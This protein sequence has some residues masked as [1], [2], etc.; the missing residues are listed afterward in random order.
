[1]PYLTELHAHSRE[2]SPCGQK[3]VQEVVDLY[4]AAGYHSLVLTN[5]YCD[6]VMNMPGKDW[7]ERYAHY[8]SAY[9]AMREYAGDRMHILLGAELRFEGMNNDYLIFGLTEEL[10]HKFPDLHKMTLKSFYPLAKDHGLLVIQAHPFRHGMQV[11]R[12]DYL[13][14][15]EIFNGHPGHDSRND[16]ARIWCKKYGKLPTSGSDFHEMRQYAT[17]GIYTEEPITSTRQLVELLKSGAYTMRCRGG[18]AER[19]GC[20][21]LTPDQI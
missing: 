12:P 19:D 11:M 13:D 17:G 15:Y 8:I 3:T 1:M 2:V 7:E 10:L 5:H 14:G 4:L 6:Y 9:H 18:A 16:I 21:D 20:S